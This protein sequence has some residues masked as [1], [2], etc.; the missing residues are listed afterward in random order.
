MI[1]NHAGY[2][3]PKGE[4][5]RTYPIGPTGLGRSYPPKGSLRTHRVGP[6]VLNINFHFSYL[7]WKIDCYEVGCFSTPYIVRK[8]EDGRDILKYFRCVTLTFLMIFFNV[9][10]N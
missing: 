5:S 6:I 1:H 3:F 9:F 10:S 2:L 7:I 4:F 8:L